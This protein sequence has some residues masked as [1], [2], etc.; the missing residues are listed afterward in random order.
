MGK[1]LEETLPSK[2]SPAP[3]EITAGRKT[4]RS[5][6]QP[7]HFSSKEANVLPD[8]I[9]ISRKRRQHLQSLW[10][11]ARVGSDAPARHGCEKLGESRVSGC[12]EVTE[13][14]SIVV[15]NFKVGSLEMY[16]RFPLQYD[17]LMRYHDCSLV[18]E[19]IHSLLDDLQR[20]SSCVSR[21]STEGKNN[22][23]ADAPGSLSSFAVADFGCG[24]GRMGCMMSCH[25]AVRALYC[26]DSEVAMLYPCM[27]NIVRSVASLRKDMKGVCFVPN[28]DC[29][30][31]VE[32]EDHVWVGD[33]CSEDC[34]DYQGSD[35][36][37]FQLCVRPI[38]FSHVQQGLLKEHK[39]CRLIVCA[40]SLSYVMRASWGADRWHAAVDATISNLLEL[41]DTASPSV[42]SSNSGSVGTSS[43]RGTSA[44]VIIE[45]LGTNT[46][47]PRR[48]NTLL[49]RLE[50]HHG[51]ERRWVRSDY[52]FPSMT[53]AVKLTRFFFGESMSQRVQQS[54]D[55]K[56]AECTGIWTRWFH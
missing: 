54:G 4:E 5:Q 28:A 27:D 32:T 49:E 22:S 38:S 3:V 9:L 24:T 10:S 6:T 51:F 2:R 15:P 30:G 39:R 53:E 18:K 45:T 44:L 16:K 52:N 34:S 20:S 47:E 29:F 36:S 7:K 8:S 17:Y 46:T 11:N 21:N 1:E 26:Y 56:L 40:W 14:D 23:E 31:R 55:T 41:L 25:G 37:M 12:V 50:T 35:A 13:P 42:K 33:T 48:Q 43:H 19:Y